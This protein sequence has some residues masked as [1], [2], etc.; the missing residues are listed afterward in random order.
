MRCHTHCRAPACDAAHSPFTSRSL[1]TLEAGTWFKTDATLQHTRPTTTPALFHLPTYPAHTASHL[2][3]FLLIPSPATP[4]YRRATCGAFPC[5]T[6]LVVDGIFRLGCLGHYL[7]TTPVLLARTSQGTY[8]QLKNIAG[9]ARRDWAVYPPHSGTAHAWLP[10]LHY[11]LTSLLWASPIQD[12]RDICWCCT[13]VGLPCC[14]PCSGLSRRLQ[15]NCR[16]PNLLATVVCATAC[17]CHC[18]AGPPHHHHHY[19]PAEGR[20]ARRPVLLWTKTLLSE[21]DACRCLLLRITYHSPPNEER[22]CWD[23]PT[24]FSR[25]HSW[26]THPPPAPAPPTTG[27]RAFSPTSTMCISWDSYMASLPLWHGIQWPSY[28]SGN[29]ISRTSIIP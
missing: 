8:T 13:P 18:L 4:T 19:L 1:D 20:A 14:M 26:R 6:L 24:A 27:G 21:R 25:G 7:I 2:R 9:M 3:H 5:R 23:H 22:V 16:M 12:R 29:F 11:C 10:A 28:T 15:K 17:R